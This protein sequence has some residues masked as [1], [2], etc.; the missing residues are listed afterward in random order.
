MGMGNPYVSRVGRVRGLPLL[1]RMVNPP[2]ARSLCIYRVHLV[3]TL[4]VASRGGVHFSPIL[5][6]MHFVLF[7]ATA[8]L[9][10]KRMRQEAQPLHPNWKESRDQS[11]APSG[12]HFYAWLVLSN[13]YQRT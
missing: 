8:F 12:V 2:V 4:I 13:V 1:P 10:W 11:H 7:L 6:S 9:A 5:S 3:Q